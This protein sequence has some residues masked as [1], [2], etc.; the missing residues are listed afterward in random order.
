MHSKANALLLTQFFWFRCIL[1]ENAIAKYCLQCTHSFMSACDTS[2]R[3]N[4]SAQV[5]RIATNL[6]TFISIA[7][8]VLII[9]LYNSRLHISSAYR[10]TF[11]VLAWLIFFGRSEQFQHSWDIPE[12]TCMISTHERTYDVCYN[13]QRF[14]DNILHGQTREANLPEKGCHEGTGAQLI[15]ICRS[16]IFLHS[17]FLLIPPTHVFV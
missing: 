12:R 7:L 1:H 8:L 16:Q 13:I 15:T 2:Y 14:L 6:L 11:M 4:P 9:L 5:C 17:V 3:P 10:I